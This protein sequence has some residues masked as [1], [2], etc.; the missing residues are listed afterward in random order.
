MEGP[1]GPQTQVHEGTCAI[2]VSMSCSGPR[3]SLIKVSD[4]ARTMFGIVARTNNSVL[5]MPAIC[6]IP[7]GRCYTNLV[8]AY[9]F[10][11]LILHS[12][13]HHHVAPRFAPNSC[14][15][16]STGTLCTYIRHQAEYLAEHPQTIHNPFSFSTFKVLKNNCN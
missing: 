15:M 14:S 2:K 1:H 6:V 12:D 3:S 13:H 16:S 7:P 10:L 5:L 11:K 8:S 4:N 9:N